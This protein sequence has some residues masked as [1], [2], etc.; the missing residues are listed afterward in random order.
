MT[1]LVCGWFP[2]RRFWQQCPFNCFACCTVWSLFRPQPPQ[3]ERRIVED[4]GGQVCKYSLKAWTTFASGWSAAGEC[5][6]GAGKRYT[7]ENC[8]HSFVELRDTVRAGLD[9]FSLCTNRW[10]ANRARRWTDAY[11]GGL[12][13][14]QLVF[15]EMQK[16][17]HR[18][19]MG[20]M[21]EALVMA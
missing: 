12:G 7:R 10:L 20:H 13:G 16:S 2:P 9:S 17:S 8:N 15:V 18:R 5:Y 14:G 11:L 19:V 6:W 4:L 3:H 1:P 21:G